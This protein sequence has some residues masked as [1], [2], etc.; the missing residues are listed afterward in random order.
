M[1][2]SGL[3][4]LA[5][6]VTSNCNLACAHCYG[7]FD[8]RGHAMRADAPELIAEQAA[9]LGVRVVTIT[10]GEPLT[11]G[12]QLPQYFQPFK[13]RG[14]RT[15]LT[16]N[17]VGIGGEV[18]KEVLEGL[19][20]IQV[21]LD[22]GRAVH[23]RVRGRG[24][25]DGAVEALRTLH[26]WGF[27]TAVMMT[28]HADNVD[29][30]PEILAV[31]KSVGARLSL[32]RYSAPGRHDRTVSASPEKLARAYELALAENLHSFDPCYQAFGYWFRGALPQQGRAIQGGCTA[33]VAALAVTADLD[34]F[35]CVRL[36]VA[37]GNLERSTLADLWRGGPL[38]NELRDRS[39]LEGECGSCNLSPVCG[40][41]RAHA[42]YSTGRLMASDPSCPVPVDRLRV[43]NA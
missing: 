1:N 21:S 7:A 38:L 31:A 28:L 37:I 11:L 36:R 20:G 32:E 10:G 6:E 8:G 9:A 41:C 30:V 42:Y 25:F 18:G 22:G 27:E 2:E 24:R 3:Y 13:R 43:L 39:R 12:S 16:T 40:G 19:D 23:D 29:D 34:V 5:V 4:L 14:M 35:T 15:F 26:E 33:G 17:G